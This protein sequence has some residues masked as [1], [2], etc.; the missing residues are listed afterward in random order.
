MKYRKTNILKRKRRSYR[1][2]DQWLT[3]YLIS[4]MDSWK[5]GVGLSYRNL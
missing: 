5:T 3:L 4:H 2:A 1:A